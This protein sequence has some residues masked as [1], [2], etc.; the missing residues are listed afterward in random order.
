MAVGN[1]KDD[2]LKVLKQAPGYAQ[3]C[4]LIDM[5]EKENF[6]AYLV[7][8][9]VRDVLVGRPLSDFDMCTSAEPSNL[10]RIFKDFKLLLHG[11]DFGTVSVVCDGQSF[12]IT[13]F[14]GDGAYKNSRHPDSV[15]FHKSLEE[16]LKRRDFT[17]NA[18]AF[19]PTRGL[20]DFSGGLDDI[21]NRV[22]KTVGDPEKRFE[23]DAL[24]IARLIRFSVQ[25]DFDITDSSLKAAL[26]RAESLKKIS[27]ERIYAEFKKMVSS[28]LHV[29]RLKKV[30]KSV[31][32][33]CRV[34]FKTSTSEVLEFQQAC[35]ALLLCDSLKV[36][37]KSY[38]L[39]KKIRSKAIV[40][41][42]LS[43]SLQIEKDFIQTLDK[44]N[45]YGEDQRTVWNLIQLFNKK[46][47]KIEVSTYSKHEVAQMSQLYRKTFE[48]AE[49]GE[50]IFEFKKT[51]FFKIAD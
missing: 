14:R 17:V 24:R 50:K 19:H 25:L 51:K 20:F 31:P 32:D 21:Q 49:L 30:F 6:E 7:G 12:E 15:N 41:Q 46:F 38:I 35:V 2:Q 39:E 3:A 5:I 22:L 48:G 29:N 9:C 44:F 28:Y 18:L 34:F 8:G 36:D 43:T 11:E 42:K 47:T 16:D 26:N 37:I 10:K 1:L 40:L 4:S 13:T 45:L 23:E 27:K 33:E